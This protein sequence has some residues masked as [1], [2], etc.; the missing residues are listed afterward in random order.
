MSFF[1]QWSRRLR[2]RGLSIQ[3]RL[4]LLICF[5]LLAVMLTFAGISYYSVRK[6]N[7]DG[8]K[9][10]LSVLTDQLATLFAQSGQ[11]SLTTM[12]TAVNTDAVRKFLKTKGAESYTEVSEVIQTLRKDTTTVQVEILYPDG[13]SI[14]KSAKD[15]K[16]SQKAFDSL[17]AAIPPAPGISKF[18]EINGKVY[19]STVTPV[20][21]NGS[22]LGY[23][24]RWRL[25]AA[26]ARAVQQFSDLIGS[27]S[28]LYVSN[29]DGSLWSDL[30]GAIQHAPLDTN[31]YHSPEI[32]QSSDGKQVMGSAKKIAGTP[33]QVIVEFSADALMA[34]AKNFLRWIMLVGGIILIVGIFLAW[35]MSLNLTRPLNKLTSAAS[36]IA[37]GNYTPVKEVDRKDE[38]GK[39]ARAFN[40]MS[41]QVNR[42][43]TGLENKV[44]ETE[45][46]NNRLRELSA[47]LQNIREQ[48]RI[49]IAREMH[50]ELGQLLTGFKMDVSWLI[51]RL[52]NKE[53]VVIH[54]KLGEMIGIVDEAVKFVRRIAAELRP[55]VL[56]DLGLIPALDWHSKEFEKRFNIK[57]DFKTSVEE[58]KTTPNIATGLFRMYQESLT[59]V[60]RHSEA[61]KVDAIL[62]VNS[63]EISLSIKDDGK[64][65]DS[66]KESKT[67]GLLGMKERAAMI[68]GDLQIISSPGS[69]TRVLISV[70]VSE[71][72]S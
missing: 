34:P 66:T 20:M 9:N 32:Y 49:H 19:Y 30:Q 27:G 39:L 11:S 18:Y 51:K 59:N 33:W 36:A 15:L 62:N 14:L 22:V 31:I 26:S 42:A 17:V 5:L 40:A 47:H 56:D 23:V 2:L 68:G 60:A 35:I 72:L 12:M 65:F 38:V 63:S 41:E 4:P 44:V 8:G 54:E 46:I 48:E 13:K 55:G 10:R 50:D 37:N 67:L 70:P 61:N 29:A 24:S 1:R 3:E 43:K 58:L 7:I 21:E 64:G 16:S 28:L 71:S 45:E 53:D 52:G 57:V 6:A 25:Q 69:G